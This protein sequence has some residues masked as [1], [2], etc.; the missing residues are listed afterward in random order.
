MKTKI[1]LFVV[2]ILLVVFGGCRKKTSQTDDLIEDKEAKALLQGIWVDSDTEEVTFEAKG[3]TIFYPDSMS[4]PSPFKIVGDTLILGAPSAK[5]PIVKQAKHIFWFK[6]QNGDV[7]KLSKSDD[8][9]D[10]L[11]FVHEKPKVL[12]VTK[13]LKRDSVIIYKGE[14]Y[15]CYVAINP[16]SYKVTRTTYNNDA[17]GVD[18][19]YYDN[20]V[21]ISV[22]HGAEELYSQDIRK[23][24]YSRF[25]PRQFLSQSILSNMEFSKVDAAGF[26]FNA[27]I[28]MPDGASCYMLDTK[29]SFEGRMSMELIEY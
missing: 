2:L 4:Q 19:V 22:Y 16:T 6:N 1:N 14:R 5:Y 18:N 23:Q 28:C 24:M 9:N 8:P 7:V 17:V 3:D 27:T 29:I 21:H 26:H 15:H 25:V 13:V 20:I 10:S 12:S 11:A